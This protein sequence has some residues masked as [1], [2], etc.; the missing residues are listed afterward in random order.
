MNDFLQ[1]RFGLDDRI[2]VV[3]GAGQ[4]IGKAIALHF[5]RA[6]AHV[7]IA[8]LNRD[9]GE[10][11]AREVRA[12]GRKSL[13]V[14]V[15]VT[16][17]EQLSALVTTATREFGRIDILVNNAG[18][19]IPLNPVALT[20]D[21]DWDLIIAR[22]LTSVFKCS[23][24]FIP[25]MTGQNKGNIIN[26]GSAVSTRAHPGFAP[27]ATA[28]AGITNFTRTL[29]AELA[30]NGIRVNCILS[31]AVETEGASARKG[32]GAER[33]Q[34]SGVPLG[35]IGKP[36]DIA[37]AAIYLASDASD[38]VTGESL[39]VKGGPLV[40]KGDMEIYAGKFPGS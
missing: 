7:V 40:R 16:N 33:A 37:L 20:R 5:A 27:Y 4:G 8:E 15:D 22:N 25:V 29:A 3:T 1:A 9:S 23:R 36:E 38:W 18:R 39:E 31:G 13:P 2:A 6:G 14:T 17:T 21:E 34:N 10:A 11:T 24:A 19:N 35:R 32:P 30:R 28:K 12:L 26:I